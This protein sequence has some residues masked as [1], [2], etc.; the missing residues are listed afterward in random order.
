MSVQSQHTGWDPT[1]SR[2]RFLGFMLA[3]WVTPPVVAGILGWAG[4]WGSG[5]AFTDYLIPIP[6]AGGALHVPTFLMAIVAV[7]L[8]GELGERVAVVVRAAFVGFA[9]LGLALLI[10]VERLFL[11]ITTDLSLTRIPWQ[12]NPLGLFILSDSLWTFA[13]MVRVPPL[14]IRLGRS[15]VVALVVPSLYLATAVTSNEHLADPFVR[16]QSRPASGRG[17]EIRWIYVRLPVSDPTFESAALAWIEPLRPERSVNVEDVAFY[18]TDSLD[19]ATGVGALPA[20][21]TLCVYE[22]GTPDRWQPG[23]AD[24]FGGHESFSDRVAT[25]QATIPHDIPQDVRA[26][27]SAHSLCAETSRSDAGQDG[28]AEHAFCNRFDLSQM[29]RDVRAV[30]GPEQLAIWASRVE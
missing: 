2:R 18:F 27:L 15:L 26:Y 19:T 20:A 3:L 25:L 5:S 30:H 7:R 12:E 17:D 4:I 6:V 24:C 28:L 23:Q 16:G 29:L 8:Y 10:D 21:R 22:D 11:G 13:S 14:G 1:M 9:L